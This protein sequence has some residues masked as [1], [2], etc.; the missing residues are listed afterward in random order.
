[1]G[2]LIIAITGRPGIGKSTIFNKVVDTLKRQGFT[3]YGFYCPEVREGGVRVGF[4]I[5]NIV[6]GDSGWLA[7]SIDKA[8]QLGYSLKGR[9]IGRYVVIEDEAVRVG[10]NALKMFVNDRSSILGIDEI[11]PM[12]LSIPVLR[13][14]ILRSLAIANNAL[15]VI[16]RNLNDNEVLSIFRRKNAKI[17]T[18]TEVNRASLPE[19]LVNE[20]MKNL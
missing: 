17:Y 16:H 4:R 15:L 12:E 7:L 20:M 10:V 13:T 1:V 6:N 9:R 18:V 5:V 19:I 8:L 11:G 3:F 2:Y 14:E